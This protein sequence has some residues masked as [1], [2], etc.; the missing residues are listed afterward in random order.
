MIGAAGVLVLALAAFSSAPV[1][2]QTLTVRSSIQY[3][4]GTYGFTDQTEILTGTG[5]LSVD[6][7]RWSAG[8]SLPVVG[9]STPFVSY[10][11]LGAT[12]ADRRRR[13]GGGEGGMDGSPG[14]RRNPSADT[15]S[16]WTRGLGDPQLRMTLDVVQSAAPRGSAVQVLGF[17]KP[18]LADPDDGIGTGAWDAGIGSNVSWRRLPTFVSAEAVFWWVGNPPETSI[19]DVLTYSAAVGRILGSSWLTLV[20]VSGS[21]PVADGLPAPV[22]VGLGVGYSSAPWSL[23]VTTSFGLTD[24]AADWTIGVGGAVRVGE[25]SNR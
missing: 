17:V 11:G 10:T 25:E 13:E 8:V 1:R 15:I 2:G 16:T 19:N 22:S 12:P 9:V 6:A 3:G 5:D 24:G 7:A 21:T 4:R 20:S 14:G 23:D 18:P